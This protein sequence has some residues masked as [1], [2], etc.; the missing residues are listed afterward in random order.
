MTPTRTLLAS[1]ALALGGLAL[2]ALPAHAEGPPAGA[3]AVGQLAQLSQLSQ[4]SRLSQT[5]GA[6]NPMFGLLAPF[7]SVVHK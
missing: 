1:A 7:T 3:G 5:T 6:L 4:L 2:T